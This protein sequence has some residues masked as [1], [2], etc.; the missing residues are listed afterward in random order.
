MK[1]WNRASVVTVQEIA[2]HDH[3]RVA[4]VGLPVLGEMVPDRVAVSLDDAFVGCL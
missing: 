2:A 4:V 1:R 3:H